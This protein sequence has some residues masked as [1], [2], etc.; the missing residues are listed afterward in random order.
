MEGGATSRGGERKDELLI[1]GLVAGW[2]TPKAEDSESAGMRHSRGVADTL[3][4]QTALGQTPAG[5]SAAT[6]RPAESRPALNWRFAAWLMGI[7]QE[8]RDSLARSMRTYSP[9]RR[10][11]RAADTSSPP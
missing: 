9:S 7:P 6:G 3:T 5:L 11:K 10:R 8:V 1:G 2:A 4:A